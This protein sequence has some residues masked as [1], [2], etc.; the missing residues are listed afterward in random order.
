[1][2]QKFI[3]IACFFLVATGMFSQENGT[4]TKSKKAPLSI[5]TEGIFYDAF[6][7]NL[8]LPLT[9]LNFKELR[10]LRVD[11]DD[12]VTICLLLILG[13]LVVR[14]RYFLMNHIIKLIYTSIFQEYLISMMLFD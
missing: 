14:P 5:Y 9:P 2:F 11:E 7:S 10:F 8:N 4:L 3:C 1:M 6:K 13:I 12:I